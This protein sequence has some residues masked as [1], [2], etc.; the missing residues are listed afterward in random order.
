MIDENKFSKIMLGAVIV[1]LIGVTS[2]YGLYYNNFSP[3]NDSTHV[4]NQN[5]NP[6]P[7]IPYNAYS[8]IKKDLISILGE[9]TEGEGVSDDTRYIDYENQ[10]W[11]FLNANARFYYGRYTRIYKNV[12]NFDANDKTNLYSNMKETLGEPLSTTFESDESVQKAFWIKDSVSYELVSKD[13]SLVLESRLA[14]YENPNNY[15][16]GERP[17]IIQRI[18]ADINNDGDVDAILLIGSK[19]SYTSLEY[20]NLYLLIGNSKGAYVTNFPAES[21]GGSN[22]QMFIIENHEK[23]N[24][25]I[26]TESDHYYI[27][28][29]NKFTFDGKNIENIYISE[30]DPREEKEEGNHN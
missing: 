29:Y 4:E 15:E 7:V 3:L 18:N 30:F 9:G 17:T 13:E 12:L 11:F 20:K 23:Q 14:Y 22:P 25:E 24:H 10:E 27:K 16:M 26:L 19:S 28:S 21:D 5:K 1:M 6:Y 8:M 2:A